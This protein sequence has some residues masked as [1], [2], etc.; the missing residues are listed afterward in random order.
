MEIKELQ[1]AV[2]EICS[3]SRRPYHPHHSLP[4]FFLVGAGVSHPSIPLA[5]EITGQCG[6]ARRERR[7]AAH[8]SG[9]GVDDRL[10]TYSDAL[11]AAHPQPIDRQRF[12]R[13]LMRDRPI[14][15]ANFRLARI[16]ASRKLATLTVTTN[17]DDLLF[18]ALCLLGE[19][20][21]RVC[22]HPATVDRIES[23]ISDLQIVHV[24]G[25]YWFYDLCNLAGEVDGRAQLSSESSL[26][27]A[28]MLDRILTNQSPL[29]VGYSGWEGDVFMS[30]L[31]RRLQPRRPLPR[32]LYWFCYRAS[33]IY[34][35][36]GWLRE[37]PNVVF[38]VHRDSKAL[39]SSPATPV[40]RETDLHPNVQLPA[41]EVFDEFIRCLGLGEPKLTRDPLGYFT[42][43]LEEA[44]QGDD[45]FSV[46]VSQLRSMHA[47]GAGREQKLREIRRSLRQS[48]YAE[49]IARAAELLD[50]PDSS[51]L[52]G[53]G[54]TELAW[55]VSFAAQN[56]PDASAEKERG[57]GLVM[58]L[59]ADPR[60]DRDAMPA[61]RAIVGK[62]RLLLARGRAGE[63]LHLLRAH[64]LHGAAQRADAVRGEAAQ[65]VAL[66]VLAETGFGADAAERAAADELLARTARAAPQRGELIERE[67]LL[68][69]AG[70]LLRQGHA[71]RAE[72]CF[73]RVIEHCERTDR[74]SEWA[75]GAGQEDV[76]T[77]PYLAAALFGRAAC[78]RAEGRCGSACE[79]LYHLMR[80]F[81]TSENS[82]VFP[83]VAYAW[84]LLDSMSLCPDAGEE[85]ARLFDRYHALIERETTMRKVR[86]GGL[87]PNSPHSNLVR[88]S[89]AELQELIAGPFLHAE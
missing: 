70:A 20:T 31:K 24:H 21:V 65:A 16:L 32:K 22:D 11:A 55:L 54:L 40:R 12:L 4:F 1:L 51:G 19:T 61:V 77:M 75:G 41:T 33:E 64:D 45:Q 43:L 83:W 26:S 87:F 42:D 89:L 62:A 88:D 7:H 76:E 14:S 2:K 79:A 39:Q 72:A 85:E 18:R 66:A 69:T 29:V 25:T 8:P 28:A 13:E 5:D 47:G 50:S 71:A 81:G 56:A 3:S 17:F 48:R 82:H 67:V 34:A 15:P 52:D 57:F 49:V 36:P 63:A 37:N 59:L 68:S 53:G 46:A 84:D 35:L 27:M 58:D 10:R 86:V 78:L 30:A 9:G 44:V 23:E 74:S 6:G 60:V 73:A 38:V 80:R